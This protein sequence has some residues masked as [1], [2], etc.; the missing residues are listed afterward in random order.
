[1]GYARGCLGGILGQLLGPKS[2]ERTSRRLDLSSVGT[3]VEQLL[4]SRSSLLCFGGS[5]TVK[6]FSG[7]TLILDRQILMSF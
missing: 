7:K 1:M 3:H 6:E 4:P 5:Y 2:L